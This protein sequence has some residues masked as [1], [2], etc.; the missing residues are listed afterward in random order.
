VATRIVAV[1]GRGGSGKSTFAARLATL[2]GG[3]QVA[4]TDDFATWDNP[5]NWWP[6]CIA[7]LLDPLQH[8]ELARYEV[9]AWDGVPRPSVEIAPDGLVILEGVTASREAFRPYLALAVWIETPRELCLERGVERDG[10]GMRAQWEAWQAA[11]DGY[12][13]R[14]DPLAYVDAVVAGV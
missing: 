8:G 9:S 14:E 10:E 5:V 3:V 2:R 12:I 1:D 4:H 11:E 6:R 7:E 13:A